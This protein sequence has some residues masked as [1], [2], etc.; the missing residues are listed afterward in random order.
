MKNKKMTERIIVRLTENQKTEIEK[1]AKEMGFTSLSDYARVVLF[2]G[3]EI[4]KVYHNY[5]NALSISREIADIKKTMQWIANRISGS[6]NIYYEDIIE[7]R[8]SVSK[9]GRK[10]DKLAFGISNKIGEKQYE[11]NNKN[12]W[13]TCNN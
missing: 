3:P 4:K 8:D 13:N 6:G 1:N 5:E 12:A 2:Q 9:I 10:V 11:R 7:L